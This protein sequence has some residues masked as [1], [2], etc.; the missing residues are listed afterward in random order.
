MKG[1]R[2]IHKQELNEYVS[3]RQDEVKLGQRVALISEP[4]DWKEQINKT[5][6][7]FVL[8]G[9]PEDIGVRANLG[10]GGAHS[11]WPAAL[12]SLVNVQQTDKLKGE[13]I[14]LLGSIDCSE[15]M[16]NADR[17]DVNG[18]R[19]LVSE[20]DDLVYPVMEAIF[21]AGKT[22]IVIGGGHNNTYPIL[23]AG[24]NATG[25]KLNCIN[26][27]A[28][29]DYRPA[30]GRHSGNGF[31][32]AKLDGYLGKYSVVGLHENYNGQEVLDAMR[33]D[34]DIHFSFYEDLF[35]GETAGVE[36]ALEKAFKHVEGAPTGIELDLDSI[37]HVL[38]SAATP[39]GISTL[40]A[41][42]Y[43]SKAA[44][45]TAAAYL[46]LPEGAIRLAD[47]RQNELTGKLVAYLVTDFMKAVAS[48]RPVTIEDV[49]L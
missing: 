10:V 43:I 25:K 35:L 32:Y 22:P 29:S 45:R 12:R 47:N 33:A 11:L 28:H 14:L 36:E 16:K 42:R 49:A 21:R 5:A 17:T 3:R 44:R 23:K 7:K 4:A 39:C 8:L 48:R 41:R 30:E 18:L 20:L 46:H 27:D 37:E 19:N 24:A 38:S 26:L 6:A 13:D 15:L 9:I 31:R 34:N 1:L 40:T 2:I